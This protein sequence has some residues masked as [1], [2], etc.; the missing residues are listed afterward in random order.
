[1]IYDVW[2][3]FTT[4]FLKAQNLQVDETNETRT[5]CLRIYINYH[6]T[7]VL[8]GELKELGIMH[9]QTVYGLIVKSHKYIRITEVN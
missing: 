9:C 2:S 8:H 1:M 3:V 7:T 5:S 6:M 4:F